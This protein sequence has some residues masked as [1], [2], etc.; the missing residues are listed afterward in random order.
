MIGRL[1]C[2]AG[3]LVRS[4]DIDQDGY[5]EITKN[6]LKVVRNW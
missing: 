5:L 6:Y 1:S 4:T 3:R 2:R